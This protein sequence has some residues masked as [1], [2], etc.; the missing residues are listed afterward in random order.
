MEV[1]FEVELK[2]EVWLVAIFE[3]FKVSCS[4]TDRE[5][6]LILSAE[7]QISVVFPVQGVI[8]STEFTGAPGA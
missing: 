4:I 7:P 2:L 6:M 3:I 8:H 5:K 1:A